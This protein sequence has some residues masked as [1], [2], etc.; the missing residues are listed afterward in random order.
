MPHGRMA[1]DRLEGINFSRMRE[2]RLNRIRAEMAKNNIGV[3][4]SWDPYTIRYVCGGYETVPTRAIRGQFVVVPVNADVH[5]FISTSFS[6]Y[7][8]ME[9]MPWM[10]GNI[11]AT[12]KATKLVA[13]VEGFK[14]HVKLIGDI[15]REAGMQ[16]EIVGL[17]GC[18][19]ELMFAEAMAKDGFKVMHADH[20]ALAARS[21]KSVDEVACMRMAASSAEA[22]FYSIQ[23]AIHP[24]VTECA[25]VG[26]GMKTLYEQGSDEVLEFVCSSGPRTNPLH[27]DFTDRAIRPGDG[28]C[29][30]ING[31]SYMG[32]KSCY[33][34]TFVCGKAT[35]EQKDIFYVAR[36]M[37]YDAIENVKA[38]N[39]VADVCKP[40]PKPEFWGCK[41]WGDV[42]GYALGHG[43]GLGL[44]EA[45]INF[46]QQFY[47]TPEEIEKAPVLEP[48]MVMALETW[49]GKPGGD[50]GVRLEE[51]VL[52]TENGYELL[53]KYPIDEL[54]ECEF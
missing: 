13:D 21:I 24:G 52:V 45:P 11:H 54:I 51:E 27:I 30:D 28:I 47:Q 34:R 9:E 53:T 44:H 43:L 4:V 42:R 14:P 50:F 38:G 1:Y 16:N 18:V 36:K 41:A 39:T 29:V 10:K 32:Y 20:I 37:L 48:G 35:Q 25:L 2:Y 12:I 5:A 33:Y 3:L 8:L 49:Y 22:A 31:N 17:D 46:K 15:I 26:A 23:K 40:W 6:R 7:K 19:S